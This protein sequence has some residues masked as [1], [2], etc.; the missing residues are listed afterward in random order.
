MLNKQNLDGK[1][2][3]K[4]AITVRVRN[5]RVEE[6]EN[7]S[8]R[9]TYGSNIIAASTDGRIV[10]AV[11]SGGRVEEYENGSHRRTYGSNAVGVQVSGGCVAV[12]TSNGRTEEYENGSHRRTY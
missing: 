8:H 5:G 3:N 9:R 10:A 2:K 6:Y 7:G 12:Q 11:T 1:G 4:M